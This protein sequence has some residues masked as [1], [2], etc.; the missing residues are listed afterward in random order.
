[1]HCT[2]VLYY[3]AVL[4]HCTIVLYYYAVLLYCIARLKENGSVLLIPSAQW[5]PH[6]NAT[7][8]GTNSD[9]CCYDCHLAERTRS[10]T[11]AVL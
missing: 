11:Q 4:M 3:C 6:V 5:A 9:V 7:G 8:R 2:T 10:R 1:M